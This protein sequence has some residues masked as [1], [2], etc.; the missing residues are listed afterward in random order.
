[1]PRTS[2]CRSLD[3]GIYDL[4]VVGAQLGHLPRLQRWLELYLEGAIFGA[5]EDDIVVSGNDYSAQA[6]SGHGIQTRE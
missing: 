1:M 5:H 2:R 6:C 3:E 4:D